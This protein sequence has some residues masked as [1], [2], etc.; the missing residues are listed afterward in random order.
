MNALARSLELLRSDVLPVLQAHGDVH[1]CYV[2]GSLASGFTEEA[3]LDV[4]VVWQH[5]IPLQRTWLSELHDDPSVE[6]FTYD[7]SDLAIDRLWR[8]DQEFNLGH[9]A[10]DAFARRMAA[11]ADGR[12][13]A[14]DL[15]TLQVRSGFLR[16]SVVVDEDGAAAGYR[17]ATASVPETAVAEACRRAR[18]DWAYAKTE[19]A[20]AA[21]RGDHLVFAYVLA[22]S[23]AVQ[24][25]ALFAVHG[26]YYPGLKWVRRVMQHLG[27]P[28][29]A[30]SLYDRVWSERSDPRPQLEAADEFAEWIDGAGL[31][32]SVAPS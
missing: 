16:G 24:L 8:H 21:D 15:T 28:S 13:L 19:L 17:Q 3:D 6:L 32:G 14:N 18:N 11:D 1:L 4:V 30:I 29:E 12:R 27:I 5:D 2:Q 23:I 7:A 20:K 26:H 25:V 10:G 31:R 22:Q 9:H